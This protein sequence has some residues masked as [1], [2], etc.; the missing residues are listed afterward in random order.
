[1]VYVSSLSSSSSSFWLI[2]FIFHIEFLDVKITATDM[3]RIQIQV[4]EVFG[5]DVLMHG[6]LME[7]SELTI[8]LDSKYQVTCL[9]NEKV[10]TRNFV[11]LKW[12]NSSMGDK[13]RLISNVTK[14]RDGLSYLRGN[15][16][17]KSNQFDSSHNLNIFC[18]FLTFDPSLYCEKIIRVKVFS[19]EELRF[20]VFRNLSCVVLL[21]GILSILLKI[22]LNRFKSTNASTLSYSDKLEENSKTENSKMENL[23]SFQNDGFGHSL[24]VVAAEPCTSQQSIIPTSTGT[25]ILRKIEISE[26]FEKIEIKDDFEFPFMYP[27]TSASEETMIIT[28]CNPDIS[29]SNLTFNERLIN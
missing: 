10:R 14:T 23:P 4:N 5:Q 6:R 3:C 19:N 24:D 17:L 28:E 11:M 18:R 16:T 1:M 26:K 13:H 9:T 8:S 7:S 27:R 15:V 12:S 2:V 22:N 29:N 25:Q 20:K 21:I